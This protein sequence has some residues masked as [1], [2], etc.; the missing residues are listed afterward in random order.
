MLIVSVYNFTLIWRS[1]FWILWTV[2][3][4][5]L[6]LTYSVHSVMSSVTSVGVW[7]RIM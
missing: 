3:T 1:L 6:A 4:R 7:V 5:D 2:S